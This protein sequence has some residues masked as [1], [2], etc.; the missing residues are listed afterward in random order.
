MTEYQ[1]LEDF[2]G[3]LSDCTTL[4]PSVDN[5]EYHEYAKMLGAQTIPAHCRNETQ[6]HLRDEK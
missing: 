3:D 1:H 5:E 4:S 6:Y 2:I